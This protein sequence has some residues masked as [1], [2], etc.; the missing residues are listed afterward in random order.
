MGPLWDFDNSLGNKQFDDNG[1]A[2]GWYVR[3][4]NLPWIGQLF[5]DPAFA[6]AVAARWDQLKPLFE[7]MPAQIV[8]DGA[9]LAPALAHERLAWDDLTSHVDTPQKMADW[10][11][12]RIDWIDANIHT[13]P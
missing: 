11:Q 10:L 3:T 6:S 5:H 8:S 2:T 4:G 13:T 9:A 1:S 12:T 7:Q